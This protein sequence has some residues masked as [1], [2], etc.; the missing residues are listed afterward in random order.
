MKKNNNE[1]RHAARTAASSALSIPVFQGEVLR[2]TL[3]KIGKFPY[4]CNG[5]L[6]Y[7]EIL[8]V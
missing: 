4:L 2:T 8:F 6:A 5:G 3:I 1:I 7:V